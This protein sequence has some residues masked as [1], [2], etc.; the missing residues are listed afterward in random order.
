M[1]KKFLSA[2]LITIP[3][4]AQS[5]DFQDEVL[6]KIHDREITLG[7]FERIY[8]KNNS[9][10][11]IEQ[12]SVEEYLELFINFKLKVIE[13]EEMGLDTT[14]SFLREFNGYVKQLAKPYLS[15][16]EEV[17]A[18]VREAYERAQYDIH[19]SHILIRCDEFASPEDTLKAYGHWLPL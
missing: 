17:E 11:S 8:K 10:P 9:N 14:Q 15:D 6:M 4:L 3:L 13:A 7:E 16:K 5:Q 1:I 12:Q 18:L 19:A 2:I